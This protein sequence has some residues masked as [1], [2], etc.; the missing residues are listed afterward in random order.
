ML[1]A[2]VECGDCDGDGGK[3]FVPLAQ[4]LMRVKAAVTRYG[5]F[6]HAVFLFSACNT[7]TQFLFIDT[8]LSLNRFYA[9]SWDGEGQ[10]SR[11][12]ADLVNKHRLSFR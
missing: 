3:L 5:R 1:S 8:T 7:V 10:L 4:F 9:S 12:G 6:P 11:M 2:V